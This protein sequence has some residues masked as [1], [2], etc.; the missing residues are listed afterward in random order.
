MM[1]GKKY[2]NRDKNIWTKKFIRY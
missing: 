1:L 2:Q